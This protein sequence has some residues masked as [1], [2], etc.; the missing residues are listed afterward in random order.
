M[1]IIKYLNLPKIIA[2]HIH[3]KNHST[4]HHMVCGVVVMGTGVGIAKASHFV[5]PVA[6]F[7]LDAVGY[8]IHGM[9]AMPFIEHLLND[10]KTS[11]KKSSNKGE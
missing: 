10:E 7:F 9:G 1:L 5:D 6:G 4:R 3:G 2:Y 11:D 8:L